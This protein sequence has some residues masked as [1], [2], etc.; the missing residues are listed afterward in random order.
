MHRDQKGQIEAVQWLLDHKADVNAKND[1]GQTPLS[2]LKWHNRG[3]TIERRK[4]IGD[5]L[6]SHGAKE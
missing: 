1:K 2:L 6:R 5:L 3:R 4:D